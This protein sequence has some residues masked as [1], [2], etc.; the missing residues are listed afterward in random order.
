MSNYFLSCLHSHPLPLETT[1]WNTPIPSYWGCSQSYKH[2]PKPSQMTFFVLS[3]IVRPIDSSRPSSLEPYTWNIPALHVKVV[4]LHTL[5]TPP[6][7]FSTSPDGQTISNALV[8]CYLVLEYQW[9]SSNIIISN[10]ILPH[11]H[12]SIC[13]RGTSIVFLFLCY[14]LGEY[15]NQLVRPH[16]PHQFDTL[17]A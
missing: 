10:S 15:D 7:D 1:N 2:M 3:C 16:G 6:I 9:I 11:V 4:L 14:L 8:L 5:N 13:N 12:I 17:R